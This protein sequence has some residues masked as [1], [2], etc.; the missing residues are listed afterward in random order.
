[1]KLDPAQ[2]TATDPVCGMPVTDETFVATY[3]DRRFAFCSVYCRDAFLK[4]PEAYSAAAG[5]GSSPTNAPRRVAYFSMEV[6]I[7][8]GMATYSG[9]LGVLAG[10]TLKS[11]ADLGLPVVAVSLLN[12]KGY[13]EQTLDQWGNQHERPAGWDRARFLHPLPPQASADLGSLCEP[14]VE[15]TIEG[16]AV[17][18]RGWQY[19]VVGATGFT[20][21]LIL[22]D[23]DVHGNDPWDCELSSYL[24]GGDDRYRLAQEIVL[25]IGGARM[26][27][28]LGHN[29]INRFHMNE[30]HAALLVLEL[31]GSGR[32]PPAWDFLGTRAECVFTTHTPVP[33]GHDQ[34]PYDLVR[35]VL[36][37]PLPDPV[38]QMLGGADRLNLTHLAMNASQYVNG[39]AKRHAEVS[40]QMFPGQNIHAVTNG[41]HSRSWTSDSFKVLYDRHIPGWGNDPCALRSAIGIPKEEVWEAHL[42]AKVRLADEVGRR[43]GTDLDGDAFT[44]G[45]ARRATTYKRT[46]L[47]FRDP[48]RLGAIAR[49]VGPIQM[50]FAGKAH[51]R[52]EAGKEMIRRVFA[53]AERLRNRVRV[54]YLEDYDLALAQLLTAGVDLWLNTPQRPLEASGTSGM[55]AAHNGVPSLSTLD[56]WW[57]EGHIEGATG[58]SIGSAAADPNRAA[59]AEDA[60]DLYHKLQ[61]VIVPLF[62]RNRDAWIDVMRHAIALN[63]S[64]F[65]THR[66]LQQY[67]TNAYV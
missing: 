66:M 12:A 37:M 16:R 44:I 58:W 13:F 1:M 6:A 20:V 53:A 32:V 52:D 27:R 63:A 2:S 51:P 25:G 14:Q 46:D 15:V 65:N 49:D 21:P 48:A 42:G 23:T 61:D 10:D 36:G 67:A 60:A 26:L 33:A 24:Y 9:G 54:V 19:D 34:F 5:A 55:K 62:Y 3:L 50:I 30:G 38:V 40:R 18:I 17:K 22:L 57:L 41:V 8:P 29:R 31:L 7:A 4:A 35:S 39:V 11:A 59:D 28:A 64:Y 43:T 45:F 56:G 47:V